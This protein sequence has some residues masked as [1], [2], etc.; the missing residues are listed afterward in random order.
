MTK[1]MRYLVVTLPVF[2]LA[3]CALTYRDTVSSDPRYNPHRRAVPFT[4]NRVE[5]LDLDTMPDSGFYYS[6][7]FSQDQSTITHVEEMLSDLYSRG[8]QITVAWYREPDACRPPEDRS[9]SPTFY[10]AQFVIHLSDRDEGI[11]KFKF[12]EVGHPRA[13]FCPYFVAEY[14]PK[15]D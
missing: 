1:T 12:T 15:T 11:E 9:I 3:G 14:R 13:W 4:F 8:F 10:R 5:Y 2:I 7:L 6:F